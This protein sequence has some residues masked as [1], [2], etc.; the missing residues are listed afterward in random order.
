MLLNSRFQNLFHTLF[1]LRDL[2]TFPSR[3]YFTIDFLIFFF[4][5]GGTPIFTQII[6]FR[7]PSF[8]FI[9]STRLSLFRL[10]FQSIWGFYENYFLLSLTTTNKILVNFSS[11]ALKMFQFAKYSKD[12]SSFFVTKKAILASSFPLLRFWLAASYKKSLYPS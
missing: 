8:F 11:L 1:V 7:L 6:V 5:E 9:P 10:L 4:F 2:F 3:Y 12:F